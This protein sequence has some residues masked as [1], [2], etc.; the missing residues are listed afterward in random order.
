M[1]TARRFYRPFA[2]N[3]NLTSP[4]Y[5]DRCVYHFAT[6]PI[7]ERVTSHFTYILYQIFLKKSIK[8]SLFSLKVRRHC[9]NYLFN[10]I[11]HCGFYSMPHET[12]DGEGTNSA[13]YGSICGAQGI[14]IGMGIAAQLSF[15]V[16]IDRDVY[17]YCP[18]GQHF[19]SHKPRDA[20]GAEYVIRAPTQLFK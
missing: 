20:C 3:R 10:M 7:R 18:V 16:P 5:G 11:P 1:S 15:N 12:G 13:R 14:T 17:Q 9:I 19:G 6:L 4:S 2:V 8:E